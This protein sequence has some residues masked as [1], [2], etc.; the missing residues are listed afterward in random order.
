MP[1]FS[2]HVGFNPVPAYSRLPHDDEMYVMEAFAHHASHCSKCANPYEVHRRGETLCSKGHRR[3]RLVAQYLYSKD[4]QAF[5]QV[6]REGNRRIRVEIPA[7][8][9]AV[10]GLLKAMDR[11][12]RLRRE[13]PLPSYDETYYVAPRRIPS[14]RN[15]SSTYEP[16]L[17]TA[18][19]HTTTHGRHS[20]R[21]KPHYAGR[22]SLFEEDMREREKRRKALQPH[23]NRASARDSGYYSS[24][25]WH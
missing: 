11:G 3:A 2:R 13:T 20:R 23:Y 9:E 18:E 5:S 16:R 8:C 21:E 14:D 19:P 1:Y 4:G 22:G 15:R 10:R 25:E 7:G 24:D 17:E 12:L 6:D